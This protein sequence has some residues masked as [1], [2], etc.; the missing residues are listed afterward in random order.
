MGRD[1]RQMDGDDGR[2]QHTDQTSRQK[3]ESQSEPAKLVFGR[4]LDAWEENEE[5]QD[6]SGPEGV[7][8]DGCQAA[9]P[10]RIGGIADAA[11]ALDALGF[12]IPIDE[13]P[14]PQATEDRHE[15][16]GDQSRGH[17]TWSHRDPR[18]HRNETGW[19]ATLAHL[20]EPL[21]DHHRSAGF[22]DA[23][24]RD[25]RDDRES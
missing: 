21:D 9:C 12:R 15:E 10:D 4:G 22:V 18:R 24:E 5:G 13:V 7:A 16:K 6:R 25:Q 14:H 17:R 1:R 19:C 3:V 23:P 11:S 2:E 8:E 20:R